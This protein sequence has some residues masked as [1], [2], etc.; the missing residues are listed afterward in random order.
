MAGDRATQLHAAADHRD[1]EKSRRRAQR[2]LE[3][4]V[5]G[6][7]DIPA[8]ELLEL[9]ED[10]SRSEAPA[11]ARRL[12]AGSLGLAFRLLFVVKL[13]RQV[14]PP[15]ELDTSEWRDRLSPSFALAPLARKLL[16]QGVEE[17]DSRVFLEQALR[18]GLGR[19]DAFGDAPFAIAPLGRSLFERSATA[20]IDSLRWG[21]LNVAR[22]LEGWLFEDADSPP[23]ALGW[24]YESLLDVTP[25]LTTEPS[26]RVR[27]P[28]VEVVVAEAEA[29]RLEPQ[30]RSGSKG[31]SVQVGEKIPA[32]RFILRAGLSR[33]TSGAYYTPQKLVRFLAERTLAP[34]IKERSPSDDPRPDR[35]L[36]IRVL[37]PAMG[38]GHFLLETCRV[39]A[40]AV[41]STSRRCLELA[42]GADE[43]RARELRTRV[44]ELT[45]PAGMLTD[46]LLDST[47]LPHAGDL[48]RR[49]VV[50]SCLWGVDRSPL[51]VELAKL[52]LWLESW[53][54]G[55]P[56]PPLDRHLLSGD[57]LIAPL[58]DDLECFP[59]S[60]VP[61]DLETS[62]YI[63]TLLEGVA[64]AATEYEDG[65]WL[66][67]HSAEGAGPR[68][69]ALG[70]TWDAAVSP[71]WAV[72]AAWTGGVV[73]DGA[74]DGRDRAFCRALRRAARGLDTTKDGADASVKLLLQAGVGGA[75]LELA[76]PLDDGRHGFDAVL[77]NPPWDKVLPLEREFFAEYDLEVLNVPTAR[78]R[79][80]LYD[81][82]L[83]DPSIRSAWEGYEAGFRR[84]RKVVE[85]AY[86]WQAVTLEER[87]RRRSGGHGD[88][89]RYFV[90]RSWRLLRK[91]GRLG[92]VLPNTFYGAL[93]AT[94]IRQLLLRRST[95]ELCL[96]FSNKRRIFE[97]GLGQRFCLIA[98]TTS[99][100]TRAFDARFGI[101]DLAELEDNRWRRDLCK[102]KVELL[103][104]M[105]PGF[106][107]F[108]EVTSAA[109]LELVEAFHAPPTSTVG[110]GIAAAGIDFYQEMNMTTDS[111]RFT[112]TTD[113][114]AEVGLPSAI[115]PRLEPH[116]SR[117]LDAGWL[118][119]HE[120]GTFHAYDD[121]QKRQPRYC[122]RRSALEA[123]A[124]GQR[125][126]QAASQYRLALRA[127]I[128]ATER[129]KSV[130]CLI[131]PG[132][133]VG[134]SA[135]TE[136]VPAQRSIDAA[137]V[138]LALGN[139]RC[140][141]Y[142]ARLRLGTNLN[143][144]MLESFPLPRLRG[145]VARFA[146][147]AAL[148]L[149]ASH[150]A[151]S[152]LW[153]KV[154]GLPWTRES[155]PT[156][157]FS[158]ELRAALDALVAQAFGLDDAQWASVLDATL[159]E[160]RDGDFGQGCRAAFETLQRD[161][162]ERFIARCESALARPVTETKEA[163][164]N[165]VPRPE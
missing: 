162:S 142:I 71:L 156:K 61:V 99:G 155:V 136:R 151:Y 13:E 143:Q 75:N 87:G 32:G 4:F 153:T 53:V 137:L 124:R 149:S 112:R 135:L 79:R 26:R 12:W 145:R 107:G 100:Q 31:R 91:G 122:C 60:H 19:F 59:G 34:L 8:N 70:E 67:I 51:A 97:I 65:L 2:A 15:R 47:E 127:T 33:K 58:R 121:L 45:R 78:E 48:C 39:L 129:D 109:E 72:M 63:T 20:D 116:R 154:T 24:I 10:R 3:A 95:L 101:E 52:A 83:D 134:N 85:A 119:V 9:D 102:M 141:N 130:L 164:C 90:E 103:E 7:V 138:A 62:K 113:A 16:A 5:Q 148:R 46:A 64:R 160:G 125:A 165:P 77:G 44:D 147:G 111:R 82:L 56:P 106:L 50:T 84:T 150:P 21:E 27:H 35:V 89:Y 49:L 18:E 133:I 81:R 123:D 57:S 14:P 94:G 37:D 131:P 118:V 96:G 42:R 66:T 132:T 1:R 17:V 30:M 88:S 139:S 74:P 159:S 76:L 73:L 115:D 25:H 68:A 98:A 86:H 22:L 104:R 161:G 43:G 126:L 114:L 105:S 158:Q 55:L 29:L 41:E 40:E 120:K 117:L 11:T 36:S 144:F 163:D 110:E 93:S 38:S 146:V 108:L 23:E 69:R 92:L 28:R 6:L 140:L 157:A 152:A 80:P 128:H 54:D